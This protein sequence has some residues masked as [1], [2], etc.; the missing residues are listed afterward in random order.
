MGSQYYESD[1][2]RFLRDVVAANPDIEK[3]QREGRDM[4]WDRKVDFEVQERLHESEVPMKGY[5]YDTTPPKPGESRLPPT[6]Q[7]H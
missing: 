7:R 2:T 6:M 4:F 1:I 3:S 5:V